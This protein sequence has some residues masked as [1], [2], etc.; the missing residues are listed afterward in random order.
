MGWYMP[1]LSAREGDAWD[2]IRETGEVRRVVL[3]FERHDGA[4]GKSHVW[5]LARRPCEAISI[6]H[7]AETDTQHC[8]GIVERVW[9]SVLRQFGNCDR[10]GGGHLDATIRR[11]KGDRG[12]GGAPHATRDVGSA[13]EVNPAAGVQEPSRR[14]GARAHN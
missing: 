8:K 10:S 5:Q 14:A 13:D 7:A 4:V 12:G 2:T 3:N 9:V 11:V 6:L 1:D